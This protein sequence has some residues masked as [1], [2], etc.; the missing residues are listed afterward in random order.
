MV[1]EK[2]KR[3][4]WLRDSMRLRELIEARSLQ[5]VQIEGKWCCVAGI[6]AHV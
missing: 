6:E 5:W 1:G 4:N 2:L 3:L